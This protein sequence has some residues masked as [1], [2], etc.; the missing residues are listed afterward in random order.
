MEIED[1]ESSDELTDLETNLHDSDDED[2]Y[3]SGSITKL[4]FRKD[5][6]KARWDENMCMAEVIEKKGGMWTTTGIIQ[7]GKLY[8]LI[9][10]ILF[11]A[12]RGALLLLDEND[13]TLDLKSIYEKVANG[14]NGCYWES[15]EAYRHFKSLGYI[16]RRHDLPWTMK[17]NKSGCNSSSLQG[18]LDSKSNKEAKEN[19]SIIHMLKDMHINEVNLVF[20]VYLPNGK[21]RKSSPGNPNLML[22]LIRGNPPSK[23]E[24]E[25]IE[26]ECKGIPVKFCYVEHGRASFFSFDKAELPVLP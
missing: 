12:E 25:N 13:M 24:V 14:K 5:V 15:F 9:E 23:T 7:N 26:R 19:I 17:S 6:S 18:T 21:F 1:W 2:P 10:E 11:L 3:T 8:C 22:C 20:D 16:V 4:Q